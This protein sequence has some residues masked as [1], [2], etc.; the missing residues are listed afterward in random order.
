M[1]MHS[2]TLVRDSTHGHLCILESY[3]RPTD[4]SPSPLYPHTAH[5][6]HQVQLSINHSHA[7]SLPRFRPQHLLQTSAACSHE[8]EIRHTGP[9][10]SRQILG[11]ELHTYE[12]RMI[13]QFQDFHPLAAVVFAHEREPGGAQ[14]VDVFGVDF[15]AVAVAL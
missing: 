6:I 5:P 4:P 10:D 13:F 8:A 1:S 3:T 12:P 11:M 7:L 15:I 2:K 14:A 9:E